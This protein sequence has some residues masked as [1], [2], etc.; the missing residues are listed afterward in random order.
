MDEQSLAQKAL[1]STEPLFPSAAASSSQF[2]SAI[3]LPLCCQPWKCPCMT[4]V[5]QQFTVLP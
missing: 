1:I 4:F 5:Q 3:L 2:L